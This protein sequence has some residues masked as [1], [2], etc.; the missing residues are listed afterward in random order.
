MVVCRF[1]DSSPFYHE[2]HK[3]GLVKICRMALYQKYPKYPVE[4]FEALYSRPPVI[5]ISSA[6]MP[7][8]SNYLCLQVDRRSQLLTTTTEF[9]IFFCN[10]FVCDDYFLQ[11][12]HPTDR[13][14]LVLIISKIEKLLGRMF[15]WILNAS[16]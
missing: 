13:I 1:P 5:Y 7:G 14:C 4:G 10:K 16:K 8:L 15:I 2:E 6:A 12:K 3:D 11:L 9:I